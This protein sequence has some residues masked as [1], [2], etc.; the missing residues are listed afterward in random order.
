M[1][2]LW[3]RTAPVQNTR[4]CVCRGS[5]GA[6]TSQA[7][8][9]V[10]RRR[11]TIGNSIT[12]LYSSIFA[13][14]AYA[15]V[16]AKD[17]KRQEWKDKIAAV[18]EE[19]NELVNEEN[20]L[21]EVL[22]SRYKSRVSSRFQQL[23][24]YSTDSSTFARWQGVNEQLAVGQALAHEEDTSDEMD[25]KVGDA[26]V[27][28][29]FREQAGEAHLE[30]VDPR[31]DGGHFYLD[32][33][34][35]RTI[36]AMQ[37]L[38]LKAL[39]IR[40]LLRPVIAPR[41]LSL[42]QHYDVPDF[43]L[44]RLNVPE[45]LRELKNVSNK[46]NSL[47]M[48]NG[49]WD[50][51]SELD[52]GYTNEKLDGMI[53]HAASLFLKGRMTLPELLL[54]LSN[55]LLLGRDPS[56]I[57]AFRIMIVTFSKTRHNDIVDLILRTLLPNGFLLSSPL[58]VTIL[59]HYR[60][61]KDVQGF[62]HFC[63][64]L[65]GRTSYK[66]NLGGL[67][68]Y[69]RTVINGHE[70]TIPPLASNSAVMWQSFIISALRFDQPERADAWM[71]CARSRGIGD[72]EATIKAYLKFYSLRKDWKGGVNAMK[73]A[74]AFI[75]S[76]RFHDE[77]TI[78][79]IIARMVLLC[80]SNEQYEFS[81]ALI[82][83]AVKS[84]FDRY[85]AEKQLDLSF[86]HDPD[87]ERWGRAAASMESPLSQN[88]ETW[89]KCHSFT[90]IMR[91]KVNLALHS[92]EVRHASQQEMADQHTNDHL[93]L[94]LSSFDARDEAAAI[95][96][97]NST[98]AELKEHRDEI[99]SLRAEVTQLKRMLADLYNVKARESSVSS[100]VERHNTLETKPSLP[101]T[102]HRP[103]FSTRTAFFKN[104]SA[105][106]KEQPP[107]TDPDVGHITLRFEKK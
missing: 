48:G 60:K 19:V 29:V 39:A 4:R 70:I 103:T 16:Q 59:G 97:Q 80:D 10:R 104:R 79:R 86:P 78:E 45:L 33:Y 55:N 91:R 71:E 72:H 5:N 106:W 69:E 25:A 41:Y 65:Q 61:A 51:E 40:L 84:G 43:P 88:A 62:D 52:A 73:R 36:R 50:D 82:G 7:P 3:S 53:A 34:D 95:S 98:R 96:A 15:D 30:E 24:R 42:R 37:K 21:L 87:S 26:R 64:T 94:A 20:R 18:K 92:E 28:S 23:R 47:R 8:T 46:L 14:A 31:E 90:S 75:S 89:E 74:I 35:A 107:T 67:K 2:K 58:I 81:D 99:G 83:A 63:M 13:C 12:A 9:A 100:T 101:E 105:S 49:S 68:F 76:V 6:T 85:L 54:S 38:S 1:L 32:N 22:S 11:L 56:R 66:P 17:K 57:N 93:S 77:K 102:Q 27:D 44:P